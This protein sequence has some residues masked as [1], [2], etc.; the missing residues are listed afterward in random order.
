MDVQTTTIE[1]GDL[2]RLLGLLMPGPL[3]SAEFEQ[4]AQ[5]EFDDADFVTAVLQKA[6]QARH[7]IVENGNIKLTQA[8]RE[9]LQDQPNWA[10]AVEQENTS[11]GG[12]VKQPYDV[13]KLKMEPRSLSVFQMLRKIQRDEIELNPDF[14]RAFV[15]DNEKKSRLIESILIRIPLPPFYLDATRPDKWAVVDGLQRLSTLR[16]FC[17]DEFILTGLQFLTEL[18]RKR[19]SELSNA[20]RILIEDDTT[21]QCYNLMPGTPAAAKYTIFSRVNTGGMVLTPQEIRHALTQ[22]AATPWLRQLVQKTNGAFH[23]VTEGSVGTLRMG[24]RELAVRALAF[25]VLGRE[26]YRKFN[27]LDT[28]L[29]ETMQ[30][31]NSYSEKELQVIAHEFDQALDKVGSIFAKYSFRKIYGRDE[32]RAPINKA[33][34]EVWVNCVWDWPGEVIVRHA[35]AIFDKFIKL[36]NEDDEFVKSIS[37]GTSNI[38]MIEKR[39]TS[40]ENLLREIMTC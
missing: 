33:L 16:D 35:P 3:A 6:E 31:L 8:G 38:G 15:W 30:I 39:F 14:Q 9:W 34:F 22:G 13:A 21:L 10:A 26:K 37:V 24:D 11:S 40:I 36:M 1:N 25:R 29:L 7:C 12:D 20:H 17:D 19:F 4:Q 2:A 27:E 18:E 28:F 5:R 32:R 23:R